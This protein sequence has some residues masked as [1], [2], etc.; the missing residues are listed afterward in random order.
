MDLQGPNTMKE[1]TTGHLL[2][3]GYISEEVEK[4]PLIITSSAVGRSL[5]S[6]ANILSSNRSAS[7][8]ALGNFWEKGIGFFFRI[9]LKYLR[10]FSLRT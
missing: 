10:A 5:G 8:F 9:L 3:E 6:N 2:E 1:D 7:G 4:E